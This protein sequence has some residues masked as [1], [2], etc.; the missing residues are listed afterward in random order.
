MPN[1]RRESRPRPAPASAASRRGSG[2]VIYAQLLCGRGQSQPLVASR[3]GLVISCCVRESC[4]RKSL[5]LL[6][7]HISELTSS[8][9]LTSVSRNNLQ[10]RLLVGGRAERLRATSL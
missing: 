6:R 7:A 10:G 2:L 4:A 5:F 1:H 8:S 9:E 3:S